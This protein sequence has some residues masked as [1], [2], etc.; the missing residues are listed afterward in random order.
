MNIALNRLYLIGLFSVALLI[1]GCGDKLHIETKYSKA[2]NF[3]DFKYYR[4]HSGAATQAQKED[5]T[6]EEKQI[7]DLLDSNIRF[8]IDE[9]LAKKG[10]IKKEQGTVDFLV[11]YSVAKKNQVDVEN[12][13][14][15][16]GY[17]RT[18]QSV[19]GYGYGYA[20]R[21]HTGIAMTMEA[22]PV[23][24]TMVD[25]YVQG[26][27][28]LDFIEPDDNKLIWQATGDK[29]LPYDEPNQKQRDELINKVIGKLLAKFPPK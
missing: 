10:M 8:M 21:Y 25:R 14:V 24:E 29:R 23:N 18:F 6:K 13:R 3:K 19:G 9:Q 15:Y 22:T 12:Q 11:N 1:S 26:S 20:G 5:D 16:D 4:W 7:D 27:M 17:S 28:S 2:T